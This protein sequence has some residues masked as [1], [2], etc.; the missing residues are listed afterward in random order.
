VS[1]GLFRETEGWLDQRPLEAGKESF[2]EQI[3]GP[4]LY[5]KVVLI[6]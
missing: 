4:A 5:P 3:D 2:D 6:P 1:D